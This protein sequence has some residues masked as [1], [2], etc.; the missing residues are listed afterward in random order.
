MRKRQE[1]DKGNSLLLRSE[2]RASGFSITADGRHNISLLRWSEPVAWFRA[3]MSEETI[4][5]FVE[6]IKFST[7][8]KEERNGR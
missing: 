3:I 5:A 2:D 4:R 8:D 1:V 7:P 6:L